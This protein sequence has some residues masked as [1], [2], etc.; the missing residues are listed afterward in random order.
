[1][2]AEIQRIGV[3]TGGGDCPGLNAVIRGV[4]KTALLRY[5]WRV[6]G[7]QDG[8]DGLVWPEKSQ[9]LGHDHVRGILTRG[10]TILGTTNR[11]NPFAY[12]LVENGHKV[13]KDF[14]QRC[15][16]NAKK[17]GLDALV[18]IGGD[19]TLNIANEFYRLGLP[20]VGVPK[21]I[22]NDLSVTEITFGFTTALQTATEAIDKIQTTAE[23]HHRV[24]IVEV[25]GRDAGWIA[26]EAGLAGDADIILIPEI[27]FTVEKVCE[28]IEERERLGRKFSI[29]VVAEGAKFPPRDAEGK[30]IPPAEAGQVGN[31]LA[32]SIRQHT[33]KDVR[34]TV[35]GHLQ[36]GGTPLAFDRLLS[37]RFGVA[38]VDLIAKGEFGRMVCLRCDKIQTTTLAEAVG[39]YKTVNPDN[40]LLRT[41]RSLGITFGD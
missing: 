18:V 4:V 14:S 33:Q 12:E 13:V 32:F 20:V 5:H 34:V 25:M 23:S 30:P 3:C 15:L 35:L 1:M 27:P 40:D 36:R 24:M 17:I 26:L 9:E 10:G 41:A 22:D 39:V 31:T 37:L 29:V 2:A 7:I 28:K 6:T 11:G 38:A 21:T 8:F 19:G 16:E